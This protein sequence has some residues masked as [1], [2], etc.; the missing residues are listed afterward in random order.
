[1][2]NDVVGHFVFAFLLINLTF[3][4]VEWVKLILY[5]EA[6]LRD[7][8]PYPFIYS[9]DRKDTPYVFSLLTRSHT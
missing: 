6:P 2:I 7:P 1:M 5:G 8:A 4:S 3:K 9:F